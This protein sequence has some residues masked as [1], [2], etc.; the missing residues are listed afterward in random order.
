[1]SKY[2][3]PGIDNDAF[4]RIIERSGHDHMPVF[5]DDGRVSTTFYDGGKSFYGT[6]C[7]RSESLTLEAVRELNPAADHYDGIARKIDEWRD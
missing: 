4:R 1:M 6:H 7:P 5:S 3:I 2:R